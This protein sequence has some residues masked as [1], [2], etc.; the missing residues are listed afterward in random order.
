ME[1]NRLEHGIEA[2]LFAMGEPVSSDR[3]A[4]ALDADPEEVRR[5]CRSLAASCEQRETGIRLI[6][7]DDSWQLVSDPGW[8]DA[9]RSLLSRKKPDRLSAAALE[10]LSVV[11]YFQPV[12]RVYVDQIRGVDSSHSIS[13]LQERE[14]IEPCGTLEAPGRPY[15]YRTT[16]SFLRTFG[17][18]SL[19]ELPPLPE[20]A[21]SE[22]GGTS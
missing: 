4:Q 9:V 22:G 20:R 13:L 3:L 12:T 2:I 15:L 16:G 7:L 19:A 21:A 11:A 10:T 14:L 18:S 8:G 17:L 6:A 1:D 5:A